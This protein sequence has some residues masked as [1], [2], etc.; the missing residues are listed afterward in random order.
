M[1]LFSPR[2][3]IEGDRVMQPED[4]TGMLRSL[5]DLIEKTRQ[6]GHERPVL[7]PPAL[8]VGIRGLIEPVL[9]NVPVVSL[10]ELPV[11]TPIQSLAIWEMS[12]AA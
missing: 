3:H 8:R 6:D 11:Q 12:Q 2:P 1:S 4:I 7:S 9:P 5:S 10:G